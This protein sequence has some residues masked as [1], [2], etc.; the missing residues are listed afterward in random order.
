MTSDQFHK[1]VGIAYEVG[2][3]LALALTAIA[4]ALPQ[5][6]K[7]NTIAMKLSAFVFDIKKLGGGTDDDDP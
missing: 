6:P 7:L 4:G 3:G 1:W 5:F 2:S